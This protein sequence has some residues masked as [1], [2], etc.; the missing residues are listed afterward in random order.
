MVEGKLFKTKLCVLYKEGRC[1]RHS[2]SFA[3]GNAELRSF[4]PSSNGKQ[5]HRVG[6]LRD[7]LDKRF[8]PRHRYSPARDAGVENNDGKRRRNMHFDGQSDFSGSLKSSDG[9]GDQVKRRKNPSTDSRVP[10]KEQL[11]EVRSDINMLDQQ[12]TQL[13]TLVQEK[14]EEAEVLTSRIREVDAQLSKEKEACKRTISKMKKFVKAHKHYVRIQD[15][16]KRSQSRLQKLGDQLD[17]DITTTDCNEED[18]SI[19]FV[20]D[21]ESPVYHTISPRNEVQK[22]SY[23]CEEGLHAKLDIGGEL[24]KAKLTTGGGDHAETMTT[25]KPFQLNAYSAQLDVNKEVMMVD[26]GN[27]SDQPRRNKGKQ[28][29]KKSVS[30]S[31]VD[32]I[33]GPGV[34]PMAP[35]TSMAA[36]AIDELVEVELEESIDVAETTT[37]EIDKGAAKYGVTTRLPFPL[38]PPPPLPQTTYSEYKEKAANVDAEGLDEDEMV[39]VDIV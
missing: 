9:T 35:S 3:H 25:A 14:V 5:D 17:S 39:D 18:L 37:L 22:N 20:S 23:L 15:E 11:K 21:E 19:N 38:P 7:K 16:L 28:K 6:D 10:H 32:K 12:K 8:S 27:D 2:C 36:H 1:H 34:G 30:I 29:R 26:D 13:R 4:F 31:S 33:K 24:K